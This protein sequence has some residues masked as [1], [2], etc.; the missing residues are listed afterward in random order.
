MNPYVQDYSSTT[1]TVPYKSSVLNGTASSTGVYV[2][3]TGTAFLAEIS[4]PNQL[5]TPTQ[6]SNT[7]L[8]YLVDLNSKECRRITGIIDDTHLTIDTE[9]TTP[10]SGSTVKWCKGSSLPSRV[11]ISIDPGSS[12][13][14]I[15]GL[16]IYDTTNYVIENG[17][18]GTQR[19]IT[20][21]VITTSS[22][23]TVTCTY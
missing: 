20:P 11:A 8:G 22:A 1:D 18:G 23:A 13:F 7:D 15:N 19:G 5:N 10:L 12:N 4:N 3:G 14:Q 17:N 6:P 16:R 9:F 2:V 21:F